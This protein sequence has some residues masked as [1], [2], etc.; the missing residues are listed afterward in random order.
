[1]KNLNTK[2]GSLLNHLFVQLS[3][4]QRRFPF[5]SISSSLL[6]LMIIFTS[7]KKEPND[8]DPIV[9]NPPKSTAV[10]V[11]NQGSFAGNN[12]SVTM[13]DLEENKVVPDYFSA[14]NDRGLGDTGYDLLIYGSK[15]YIITNVS[16]QLEIVDATTFKSIKQI[17]FFVA[18]VPSQPSALAALNGKVF[19]SSYNGVVSVLD[20]MSLE[21]TKEIGTGL[22]PDALLV[23]N[24]KLW[25]SNSG[26]LNFP[27]YDSTVSVIDPVTQVEEARIT[28]GTNPYTLQSDNYGDIYVITRGNYNDIKM[29]L[30]IIDASTQ[31]V[32][33]TFEEFEAFNLT[34]KGDTA[35]VYHYDF[36]ESKSSIMLINVKTEEII[37][38]NFITD[39]TVIKTVYGI[40]VDPTSSDVYICDA[41]NFEGSGKVYCFTSDG[42]LKFSFD[43]GV[44]PVAVRFLIK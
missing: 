15:A 9:T 38:T 31:T 19:I 18:N 11:L 37:T 14:Q 33:Y 34:I 41:N 43:A 6:I 44:N 23:S 40:A 26:G 30:K 8:N 3:S 17:P 16:S 12:A 21:I 5:A 2:P 13:Y 20:T 1:M 28:V 42:K 27:D 7:C 24:N 4:K 36:I 29:R 25:V 22:N 10:Y 39:G 35:Y 32:K